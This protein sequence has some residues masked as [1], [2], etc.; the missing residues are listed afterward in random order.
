MFPPLLARVGMG[1]AACHHLGV[2]SCS[3][4]LLIT[5]WPGTGSCD[6]FM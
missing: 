1:E 2:R 3:G 5:A 4:R 6:Q